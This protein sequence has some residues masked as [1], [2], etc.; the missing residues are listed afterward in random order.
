[1]RRYRSAAARHA[2]PVADRPGRVPRDAALSGLG[3]PASGALPAFAAT[4]VAPFDPAGPAGRRDMSRSRRARIAR[5]AM[6]LFLLVVAW[7]LVRYA[8]SVD[9]PQVLQALRSYDIAALGG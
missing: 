3:R 7:L 6:A 9:W 1:M 8:R 5:V 2:D 4:A